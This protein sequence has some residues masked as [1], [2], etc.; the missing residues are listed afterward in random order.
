[1][2]PSHPACKV[3]TLP[4]I[5]FSFR[6]YYYNRPHNY[7]KMIS[8]NHSC[9]ASDSAYTYTF[10]CSIVCL[11]VCHL[12]VV[13]HIRAPCLNCLM[14][15]DDIVFDGARCPKGRGDLG[16]TPQPKHAIA[17]CSQTV[18]LMLSSGFMQMRSWVDMPQ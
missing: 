7:R 9:S 8:W 1:M 12:P 5:F 14:D 16:V 10:L 13:F 11:S 15:L 2:R 4:L 3:L 6:N 17:N 18:G